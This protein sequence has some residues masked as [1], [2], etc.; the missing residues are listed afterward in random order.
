M[1]KIYVHISYDSPGPITYLPHYAT[2]MGC[3][4]VSVCCMLSY[5]IFW[6]PA[7]TCRSC[8]YYTPRN[9]VRGVY[10]IH[11]VCLSVCLSVNHS[12]P[13]CSIYSSGRILPIFGTNI[14]SMRGCVAC[15]D[16]WPWPITSRS[17]GR[18][19]ENRVR[20]VAF[21]VLDGLFLYVAQMITIIRGCV[22]CNVSF[23]IWKLEFFAF[24]FLNLALTLK[25]NL[26]FLIDSFHI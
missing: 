10:W 18:D 11:L 20:S 5:F 16:P 13:P 17:F 1:S 24:F 9:E 26:Q 25:K 8:N 23:R 14:N 6:P 2:A 7:S 3:E 19:L 12:C 4:H 15:Y 22:A 21:T